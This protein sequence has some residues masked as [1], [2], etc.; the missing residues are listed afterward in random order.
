MIYEEQ[1][2]KILDGTYQE[3]SLLPYER[4]L[5][6]HYGV[7]RVTVRQAMRMLVEDGLI[8]KRTGVGSFVLGDAQKKTDAKEPAA[9]VR[10]FLFLLPVSA[11]SPEL[12][13]ESYNSELF[14]FLQQ[15]CSKTGAMLVYM[16]E[17]DPHLEN[18]GPRVYSGCFIASRVKQSVV[19]RISSMMP[20]VCINMV[21]PAVP[22]AL[23]ED[24]NGAYIAISSLIKMGHRRIAM[25]G[26]NL[27]IYTTDLRTRG[28]KRALEKSDIP[29]D[30]RYIA[31]VE[32]SQTDAVPCIERILGRLSEAQMPTAFFFQSDLLAVTGMSVLMRRGLRVP[33]DVSVVGFN[34]TTISQNVYPRLASV[35]TQLD[36][37]ASESLMLMQRMIGT[38]QMRRISVSIP[39]HFVLRESV[40]SL[41]DEKTK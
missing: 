21:H 37:L 8:E 10:R 1:R 40:A 6:Q 15:E 38:P 13:P 31:F 39:A 36:L 41:E 5:C 34:N 35:D 23:V 16:I 28:Y 33:E 3:G 7:D 24:E 19:D 14:H 4:E 9:P 11:L 20:T 30:E 29:F 22:S 2:A 32:N 27:E 12:N 17:N 18:L 26:N 25:V